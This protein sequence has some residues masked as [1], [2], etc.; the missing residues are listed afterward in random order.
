MKSIFFDSGPVI[1]L[2]TNNLLWI[3]P[4]L[5]KRFNGKFLISARVKRELIDVPYHSKK[6]KFEALQIMKAVEDK[7]FELVPV[8]TTSALA[9]EL[10]YLANNSFFA[11]GS[12]LRLVHEG[13][14]DSIAG[15]VVMNSGAVVIDERTT[16]IMIE[17]WNS[18]LGL[19]Q[20][21]LHTRISVN[22]NNLKRFLELIKGIKV[23]RSAELAVIAYETGLLDS[24]L[25]KV[26]DAGKELL[27]G[28]LWGIKLNG[29]SIS[30]GEIE[31][32]ERAEG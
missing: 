17:N 26:K 23:I 15:A 22:T 16:R 32:I 5:K 4:E 13:E 12:A 11:R 21:K 18:L 10:L 7:T 14:I 3:L 1:S 24:Y 29:C 19:L 9:G 30:S 8:E 2:S 28:I 20:G 25:P 31:R 6:F 27:D